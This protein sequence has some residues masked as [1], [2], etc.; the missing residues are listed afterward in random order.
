MTIW[1]VL[2]GCCFFTPV[3]LALQEA[4]NFRAGIIG[5]VL[6]LI[7]GTTIGAICAALMMW[8]HN[9]FVWRSHERSAVLQNGILLTAFVAEALWVV[10]S[11]VLGWQVAD[12][13]LRHIR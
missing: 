3:L 5:Y 1:V 8:V 2:L 9:K 10:L 11:G 4:K 13:V 6:C 12:V 7:V